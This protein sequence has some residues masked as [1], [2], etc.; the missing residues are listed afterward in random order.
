MTFTL[1]YVRRVFA[2]H[3]ARP[4]W[5]IDTRTTTD[6]EIARQFPLPKKAGTLREGVVKTRQTLYQL[7]AQR[8]QHPVAWLSYAS[9][10]VFVWGKL[11]DAEARAG[12]GAPA[13]RRIGNVVVVV[14]ELSPPR[15]VAAALDVLAKAK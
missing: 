7:V 4:H 12:N 11:A 8:V 9:V 6:A 10:Q 3:G 5:V 1:A 14:P 13:V 2:A 15:R